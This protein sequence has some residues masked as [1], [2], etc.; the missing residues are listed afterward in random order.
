MYFTIIVDNACKKEYYAVHLGLRVL[1]YY[2]DIL[3]MTKLM[4]DC[5]NLIKLCQNWHFESL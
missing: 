3:I 4:L 2:I 1:F 5:H